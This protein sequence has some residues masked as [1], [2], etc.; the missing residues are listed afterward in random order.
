MRVAVVVVVVVAVLSGGCQTAHQAWICTGVGVGVAGAGG[1]LVSSAVGDEEGA[2]PATLGLALV[3]S[4]GL[5]A[6]FSLLVAVTTDD[7]SEPRPA[8]PA[9]RP[10]PV[11]PSGERDACGERRRS[12][13]RRASELSDPSERARILRE[14]PDCGAPPPVAPRQP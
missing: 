2:G 12:L 9:V 7:K 11:A 4:G 8:V 10:E 14:L 5:M 6:V 3:V 1:L 13:A